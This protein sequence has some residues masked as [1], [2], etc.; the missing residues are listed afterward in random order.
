M[1][2]M[3]NKYR[4]KITSTLIYAEKFDTSLIRNFHRSCHHQRR[5]EQRY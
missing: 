4:N 2:Q 5:Q 1:L 3:R